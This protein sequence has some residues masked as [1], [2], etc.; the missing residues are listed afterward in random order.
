MTART[1][2]LED[3]HNFE[4][5]KIYGKEIVQHVAISLGKSER[6]LYL[7]VQFARSKA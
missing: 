4:R 1:R 2:I 3:N 5:N 7:A 6:T